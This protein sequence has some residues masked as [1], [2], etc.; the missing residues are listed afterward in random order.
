MWWS[1]QRDV[2]S[3]FF[4]WC[5]FYFIT[6]LFFFFL[7]EQNEKRINSSLLLLTV[8]KQLDYKNREKPTL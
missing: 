3:L 8:V 7:Y 4:I 6:R 5:V 2:R 1:Q